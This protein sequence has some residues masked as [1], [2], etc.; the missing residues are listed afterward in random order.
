[1]DG[2]RTYQIEINGVK[3]ATDAVLALNKMLNELETR[4]QALQNKNINIKTGGSTS[5]KGTSALS[6]EAKLEKQ[7]ADIDAKREAYSKEIYQNYLAAKDVLSETVKDQKAISAQERLQANN[8]TNTMAGL[9]QELADLKL[10]MNGTDISDKAFGEMTQR[11][12]ELTAKLKELEAAYGTFGRNVGNYKSAAD[13]FNKISVAVGNTVRE[14]TNYRQA[15]KELKQE[16]FQLANTLGQESEQYKEIDEAVKQLESD[17][18]DLNKSSAFMD[19]LLDTMQS[20]TALASVGQGLS[21]L[22]GFDDDKIQKSIQKLVALQNVLK[23]IETIQLQMQRR[24]G[25]GKYFLMGSQSVDRFVAK[26]TGA[27]VTM[28]GLA[29]S[30]RGATL[31][32]RGLSF[33]LKGIGIGFLI[34]LIP[35]LID[36]IANIGKEMTSTESKTKVLDEAI[37]SLNA[38]FKDRNDLL[39]ASY[40]RGEINDEELLAKSYKE[41]SDYLSEQ[42]NLLRERAALMNEQNEG[43]FF[44]WGFMD[45]YTKGGGFTGQHMGDSKTIESYSWLSDLIPTLSLSVKNVE[46][47]EKAFKQ[48]NEAINDNQDY[49]SKWGEGLGDW[50]SSLFTTVSDTERVMKGLGNTRLNEFV[51]SFGDA[52][53]KFKEANENFKEGKI[54]EEQFA[55]ATENFAKEMGKLKGELNSSDVLRSVIA[56]LDQYIPD[57]KVRE[58]IQNIINEV[59]RLD[60]AFNMT[61]PEQIRHWMQVRIDGMKEGTAKIKAQIKA[62]MDYEIAQYGKTAEQ[63]RL[64]KAKYKKK[65]QDDLKKYNEQEKEKAKKHAKELEAVEREL[66]SLRI[67]LMKEGLDKQIAQL[68]EERR[69]KIQAAKDNGIRVGELTKAINDVYDKKIIDAKKDWATKVEQ[70]YIDMWNKIHQLQHQNAQ[71]NFDNQMKEIEANYQKLQDILA[72]ESNNVGIEYSNRDV[73]IEKK[74]KKGKEGSEDPSDYK[75]KVLVEKD[76]AYTKRLQEEYEKRTEETRKYYEKLEQ[77]TIDAENKLYEEKK[78][79]AEESL[80]NEITNLQSNYQKEDQELK[81]HY[82]NGLITQ[83]QYKEATERLTK[84]RETNERLIK[85]RYD[86]EAEQREREHNENIEQAQNESNNAML[87]N[88]RNFMNKLSTVGSSNAEEDGVG[89]L[90][91]SSTRRRNNQLIALY[92]QLRTRIQAEMNKLTMKLNS[93]TLSKK[94]REDLKKLLNEYKRLYGEVSAQAEAVQNKLDEDLKAKVMQW[95]QVWQQAL[96]SFQE[97]MSTIWSV[98]DN[99]FD[100]QQEE[101]DKWNEELDDALN[102]QQDI[103]NEHKNNINSIED[104]LANAR[105][106]RRQHLIDQLNAE[107]TAQ[108]A[109]QKEEQKI[110][111]QKEAAEKKQ[112]KLE[113][114]RKKAQYKRDLLQAVVN[115]AMAVTYAAI[116]HYPIPAVPMMA[117]AAGTTAAQ[118]AIMTANKPYANGGLLEGPSHKNGGIPVGNTGIEVEGK[119]YV[120]RK[121]STAQN[122]ELLDYINKSQ[123]KLSLDDFIDFYT[124]GKVKKSFASSPNA[125]FAEGGALPTLNND[126]TFDDRLL[127]AF[128]DYSNRPVQVAVVDINKRQEAV[129]SVQVLSGLEV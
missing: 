56:N 129:R 96:S 100:K 48:C 15:I 22:F 46:E 95:V 53:Q 17:Y 2:K 113:L 116:N 4:I 92:S 14:Y 43:G 122:I 19:N 3:E 40:L 55:K 124:K 51:A 123:R 31:A 64:I 23:G 65:E 118:I 58:A 24:E 78:Q 28:D 30:T 33:A 125:K 126:Y 91:I 69:Q 84:E 82:E 12:G 42:V 112:E 16:R 27:K 63:I 83:E 10:V 18:N 35:E 50:V 97:I 57:E 45:S 13:G 39:A 109:A 117:L 5:S 70:V 74:A 61:S 7:I 62:D 80:Q 52:N 127:T 89:F 8:Y 29:A 111:K 79:K 128:E 88:Y 32:V 66:N 77:L 114:E 25:L 47:V 107:M 59:I 9:K 104:E 105:G 41:Q 6:E 90:S 38:K 36:G 71:L 49:F 85:E 101:L 75:Y 20:F 106:D 44:S 94:E 76:E 60:D 108:R 121:S 67:E 73:S 54:N 86:R 11:A 87:N 72:R 102:K 110:Q 93:Q 37:N 21:A 115:G 34:A 99:E 26:L 119:E 68:E 81:K 103:I 120:I 1:M 98:Q